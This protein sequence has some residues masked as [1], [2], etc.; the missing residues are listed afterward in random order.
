[1]KCSESAL[2]LS[3]FKKRLRAGLV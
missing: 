1:M 3:V 2:I